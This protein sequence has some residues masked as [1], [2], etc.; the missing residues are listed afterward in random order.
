MLPE[1]SAYVKSYDGETKWIYFY[2]EDDEVLEKYN[3]I[4]YKVSNSIMEELNCKSIYNKRFLNI[5]KYALFKQSNLQ[6][7]YVLNLFE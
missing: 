1:T 6:H 3:S 5:S 2:I 4:W 7:I